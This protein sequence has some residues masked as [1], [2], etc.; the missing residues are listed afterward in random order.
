[1]K[2]SLISLAF[3]FCFI[4]GFAQQAERNISIFPNLSPS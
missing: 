3:V 4:A 2:R 1:M